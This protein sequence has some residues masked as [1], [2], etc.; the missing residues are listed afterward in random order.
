MFSHA[1]VAPPPSS[2][3]AGRILLRRRL[4]SSG[5]L[6]STT[7]AAH[8]DAA[9]ELAAAV[10]PTASRLVY[11]GGTSIHVLRAVNA[12]ALKAEA[13]LVDDDGKRAQ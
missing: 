13:M 10:P 3:R 5:Q 11:L 12:R 1:R 4:A 6:P 7:A 2:L 8:A 9:R